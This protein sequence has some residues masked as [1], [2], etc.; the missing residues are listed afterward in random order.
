M[1]QRQ[2]N[3]DYVKIDIEQLNSENRFH[4]IWVY[5]DYLDRFKDNFFPKKI[6][7]KRIR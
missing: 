1:I 4:K 2:L 3:D 7:Y 6:N 5:L